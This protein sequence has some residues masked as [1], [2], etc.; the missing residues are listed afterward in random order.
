MEL[1]ALIA[2]LVNEIPIR[3][4]KAL[5]KLVY[6]CSEAGVPI[7]TNFRLHI[8]GPYSNEVA[9]EVGEAIGCEIVKVGHD[10]YTFYKGLSCD[11]VLDEYKEEII[12]NMDKIRRVLNTFSTFSPTLLELYATVHF[13]ATALNE[14]Y[15][16]ISKERI[17]L[18]VYNAKAGKFKSKEIE[19]AYDDLV[20]WGWLEK[21]KVCSDT[22]F[23]P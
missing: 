16:D 3:G 4:K 10:G 13:I 22:A 6:F 17:I 9:D 19:Q 15:D 5:Q 20:T 12:T 21:S 1:K 23:Q 14:A 18:E 2:C 8:Y 7:Y 11:K